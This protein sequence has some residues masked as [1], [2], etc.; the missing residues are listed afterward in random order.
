MLKFAVELRWLNNP[1]GKHSLFDNLK[2]ESLK[3]KWRKLDPWPV[4]IEVK[5]HDVSL[6]SVTGGLNLGE[7]ELIAFLLAHQA[8]QQSGARNQFMSLCGA[9]ANLSRTGK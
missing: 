8:G 2:D 4:A 3:T 6:Q 5:D 7:R 9:I 1:D